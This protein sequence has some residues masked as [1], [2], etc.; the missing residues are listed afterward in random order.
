MNQNSE[1]TSVFFP[2]SDF[3]KHSDFGL[4]IREFD[5]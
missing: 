3:G 5:S 1:E 2:N 4:V